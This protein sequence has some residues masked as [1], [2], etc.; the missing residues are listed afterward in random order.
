M[1]R[2]GRRRVVGVLGAASDATIKEC[3]E[4]ARNY[5]AEIIV[6][7]VQVADVVARAK[8]VEAMGASYVGI[9]LAI[10]EQM[11]GK[12]PWDTL[13][14]VAAGRV[15]PHRRRRRHQLRDRAAGHRSRRL[16]RHRRRRDHQGRRRHRRHPTDQAGHGDRSPS[17]SEFFVRATGPDIREMLA[18]VSAANVSD[19]LHRS[20]DI[21][22]MRPVAPGMKLVGP[23]LTVRT[24]PGDWAKPVEAIDDGAARRRARHRRRRRRSRPSGASWPPTP[25]SSARW[26]AWSSWGGARDTGDIRALGFP[27]FSLA[28]HSHRR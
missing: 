17:K 14:E 5:G 18:R 27:L 7:M 3:V 25:P 15:D 6:D 9:H 16:H 22:G 20:G 28:G 21:P 13:R 19:A 12:T 24:Y 11:Q 1:R 8:E 26:P 10:D 4:A 23:A 2:Q